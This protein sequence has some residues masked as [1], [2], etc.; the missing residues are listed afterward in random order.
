MKSREPVFC[1]LFCALIFAGLNFCVSKISRD[2]IREIWLN[3]RKFAKYYAREIL[4]KHQLAKYKSREISRKLQ[5]TKIAKLKYH[6]ITQKR[7]KRLAKYILES[8]NREFREI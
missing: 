8:N 5:T 6:E 4:S 7:H 3:S 2:L 1:G